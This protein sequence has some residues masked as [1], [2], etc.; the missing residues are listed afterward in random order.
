M[1][2]GALL[3]L[4]IASA[5]GAPEPRSAVRGASG[6]PKKPK[7][8]AAEPKSVHVDSVAISQPGLELAPYTY[9][10]ASALQKDAVEVVVHACCLTVADVQ[11]CRGDWG[12]C[13]LPLVPGREAVGVVARAGAAVKGLA[14]GDRVAVLLGT[15]L[16]SE[17]DDDGADRSALD[18]LTT[19]AATR[20]LRVPARWAFSLPLDLPSSQAAGLMG[21]GGAV[22]SQLATRK[23]PKGSKVGVLGGGASASL[24]LQ[25]CEALG[26]EALAVGVGPPP[27][28]AAAAAAAPAE[29]GGGD[30]GADED[31]DDEDE[32]GAPAGGGW[33]DATSDEHLRLHTGSFDALLVL[34]SEPT[35]RASV[36]MS[37]PYT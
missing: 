15:G 37:T 31:E 32:D 16:D 35:V 9:E 27:P 7:R 3:V 36:H 25:L 10:D 33:V 30:E 24:A 5:F 2:G 12:P 29:G 20:R 8:K 34:S 11:Q 28:S 1:V 22:W 14:V 19:G 13:L 26:M 18:Q 6:A 21:V 17:A 4:L 23:L